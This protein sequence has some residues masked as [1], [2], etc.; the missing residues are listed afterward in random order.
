M[1]MPSSL[2]PY[3][4]TTSLSHHKGHPVDAER[5]TSIASSLAFR[6]AFKRESSIDLGLR[7]TAVGFNLANAQGSMLVSGRLVQ[8]TMQTS[9]AKV[10]LQWGPPIAL[11]STSCS[12]SESTLHPRQKGEEGS[13]TRG[14]RRGGVA[15]R[16]G[17]PVTGHSWEPPEP[18]GSARRSTATAAEGS[19]QS[20][21]D[22]Q[23]AAAALALALA[24]RFCA[25]LETSSGC[26]I[27][28]WA[29]R[30]QLPLRKSGHTPAA[31]APGL[32]ARLARVTFQ[33]S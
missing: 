23:G 13:R 28:H 6:R 8:C 27:L 31:G 30:T 1:L 32:A 2:A 5:P 3:N 7:G 11:Q 18:G 16:A 9:S 4:R 12:Q 21:R 14:G 17:E 33:D 22:H 29:P 25:P 26:D 20:S 19:P 10:N 24:A 15:T